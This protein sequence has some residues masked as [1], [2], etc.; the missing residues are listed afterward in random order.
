MRRFVFFDC[1]GDRLAGTI[2]EAQA[3]TGLLIISGGNEIRSG[4][5]SNQARLAAWAAG[6][7]YPAFRYDRPGIGDSAGD[8]RGYLEGQAPLRAAVCAFRAACPAITRIAAFGNCDAAALLIHSIDT[9]GID[10]LLLANPWLVEPAADAHA[11][12]HDA[13]AGTHEARD[14]A[15]SRSLPSSAAIRA[16]YIARLGNPVRLMRDLLGGAIDLRKLAR[17]L[18]RMRA[19]DPPS[20][21]AARAASALESLPVPATLLIARADATAITFMAAWKSAAFRAARANARL[22]MAQYPTSSHSFA[23]DAA[24]AW[25]RAHILA[26]LR[27]D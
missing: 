25:L 14:D 8:N 5:H 11:V 22:T 16:R 7:G 13:H 10:A 18:A 17:G 3:S 27:Q 26:A 2:D 4:G 1:A 21:L 15:E 24:Q 9:P 12:K 20:P 23:D 6:Q 19:A